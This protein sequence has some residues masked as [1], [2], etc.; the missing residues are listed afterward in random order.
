MHYGLCENGEWETY[1]EQGRHPTS[2]LY[3]IIKAKV[4]LYDLK[5]T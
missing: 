5:N 4:V 1:N 3:V 2:L